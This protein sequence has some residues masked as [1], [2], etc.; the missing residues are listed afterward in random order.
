MSGL[1]SIENWSAAWPW[2]IWRTWEKSGR[3]AGLGRRPDASRGEKDGAP[4]ARRSSRCMLQRTGNAYCDE[5]TER[6]GRNFLTPSPSYSLP[7]ASSRIRSRFP[8]LGSV[9]STRR[10]GRMV[11]DGGRR[12]RGRWAYMISRGRHS[13]CPTQTLTRVAGSHHLASCG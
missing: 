8:V 7:F 3:G 9:D 6:D 4:S 11:E 5:I 13:R 1:A 2:R 12:A 10:R